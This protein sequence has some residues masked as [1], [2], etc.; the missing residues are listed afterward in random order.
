M[1]RMNRTRMKLTGARELQR[2]LQR[3]PD[4]LQPELV[5]RA[6][7]EAAEP[8]RAEMAALAPDAPPI[9]QGLSDNIIISD[10]VTDGQKKDAP[11]AQKDE[12]VIF[13]GVDGERPGI[14]PHGALVEWGTGPRYHESGK[15]VGQM[16]AIPFARP[17]FEST[18]K[19]TVARFLAKLRRLVLEA[20]DKARKR[21]Q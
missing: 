16:P 9:G 10:R 1:A 13:V 12:V 19:S 20:A 15:Y 11:S 2:A 6:L 21:S 18:A 4:E 8:M 17:A 3:L 7:E 14:A 5:K